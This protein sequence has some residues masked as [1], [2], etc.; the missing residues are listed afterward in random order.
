[1]DISRKLK[2]WNSSTL[3]DGLGFNLGFHKYELRNGNVLLK[4][5]LSS[6]TIV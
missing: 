5:M 2:V 3:G 1:M 6:L 4:I